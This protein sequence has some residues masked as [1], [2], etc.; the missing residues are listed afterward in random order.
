MRAHRITVAQHGARPGGRMGR[1]ALV[2][3]CARHPRTHWSRRHGAAQPIW[4]RYHRLGGREAAFGLIIIE[5]F[6]LVDNT[7]MDSY[8]VLVVGFA[9][10]VPQHQRSDTSEPD[11]SYRAFKIVRI[12]VAPSLH[13][14]KANLLCLSTRYRWDR[15]LGRMYFQLNLMESVFAGR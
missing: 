15:R 12:R 2:Y 14:G 3:D 11:P 9:H 4:G 8:S 1:C 5:A 13:D 7:G 10:L 6:L